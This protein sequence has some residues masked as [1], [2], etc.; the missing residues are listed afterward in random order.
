MPTWRPAGAH[1]G[2]S[3]C[4]L[5]ILPRPSIATEKRSVS[6][7]RK[8]RANQLLNIAYARL[9]LGSMLATAHRYDEAL[10]EFQK[11]DADFTAV[12]GA[13]S[14]PARGARS[15]AGSTLAKLG[16]LDEADAIFS[17]LLGQPFSEPHQEGK[18]KGRLGLLRSAQGRHDEALAL[19]RAAPD[20][21]AD[22]ASERPRAVALAGLGDA[23]VTAGRAEESLAVSKEAR[24]LLLKEQRNGS[25]ELADIAVNIARAQIA[26][27]HADEAL[28]PAEEAAAF[29]RSF[30]PN[31]RSTG[32]A[33]L[34]QAR[35]L[36]ATG[37][38]S[39]AADVLRQARDI[40]ATAGLRADQTL[41]AQTREEMRGAPIVRQ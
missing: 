16:R 36:A 25:P 2:R 40:L 41:L 35:A 15:G 8:L 23:L 11:A 26:L 31:H 29:W 7:W 30:D 5:E 28:A 22:A 20:Y 21:F 34:W 33:L 18:F 39:K 24:T 1:L 27:G 13:D 10:D 3:R 14:E 6:T 4:A 9:N 17:A 37:D 38:A 32:I 12:Q 19:L